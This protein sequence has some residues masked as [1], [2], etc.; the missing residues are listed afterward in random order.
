MKQF[1]VEDMLLGFHFSF[2]FISPVSPVRKPLIASVHIESEVD[3][4]L[5]C[6]GKD[7][8]FSVSSEGNVYEV[9]AQL[10]W[11]MNFDSSSTIAVRISDRY[12]DEIG[13]AHV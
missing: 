10:I 6:Y 8:I 4:M 3:E 12:D 9:N 7:Y 1:K 13:R 2:K 11:D 5:S